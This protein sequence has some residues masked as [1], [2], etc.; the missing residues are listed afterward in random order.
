MKKIAIIILVSLLGICTTTKA[1]FSQL[2]PKHEF[3]LKVEGSYF[4][5]I[6]NIGEAGD[7]GFYLSKFHNAANF[8]IVAGVNLSQDWFVGLGVGANYYHNIK[9]GLAD[10]YMGIQ[11][12]LDFDFRPIWQAMMG[13]DYQP[14]TIKVAPIVGGRLGGSMLMGDE[15]TYGTTMTIYGEFYGGINWY[16]RHGLRN[17]EHNWHSFYATIGIAMMQQT[18]FLPLRIGWRW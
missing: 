1:Q 13:L 10:P 3:M 16:Y 7:Y 11:A 12:F 2:G 18:V 4:P 8:N 14:E 5:F 17:M 9:Q 6:G 15:A